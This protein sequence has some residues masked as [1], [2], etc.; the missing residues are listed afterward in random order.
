M[1]R[2]AGRF[3]AL[4]VGLVLAWLALGQAPARAGDE[5]PTDAEVTRRLKRL[6]SRALD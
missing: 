3:I 2:A 4:G 1:A 5:T 6:K